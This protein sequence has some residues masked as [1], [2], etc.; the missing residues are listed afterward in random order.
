MKLA[1]TESNTYN[2][3]HL[4][5]LLLCNAGCTEINIKLSFIHNLY[6]HNQSVVTGLE[7]DVGTI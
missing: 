3:V 1:L 6:F 4:T 2:S 5:K 7:G